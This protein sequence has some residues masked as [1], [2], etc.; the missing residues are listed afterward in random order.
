MQASG[1]QFDSDIL[2]IFYCGLEKSG[3]SPGSYP[4][5]L[6]SNPRPATTILFLVK[7]TAS[8]ALLALGPRNERSRWTE[9][10]DVRDP[11]VYSWLSA[12]QEPGSREAQAVNDAKFRVG[13]RPTSSSKK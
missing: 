5:D 12:H 9:S 10:G 11:A 3:T 8:K 6:G 1:R 4:G 13:E 2:H 7:E